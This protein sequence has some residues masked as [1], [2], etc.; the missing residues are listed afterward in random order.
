MVMLKALQDYTLKS[1]PA[2][3]SAYRS[4]ECLCELWCPSDWGFEPTIDRPKIFRPPFAR[5]LTWKPRESYTVGNEFYIN[6]PLFDFSPVVTMFGVIVTASFTEEQILENVFT[7]TAQGFADKNFRQTNKEIGLFQGR[8]S[9]YLQFFYTKENIR[10]EGFLLYQVSG[11]KLW[12][13]DATGG[14]DDMAQHRD[15]LKKVIA[16]LRTFDNQSEFHVMH[17]TISI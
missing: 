14:A 10:W 15:L 17:S 4:N 13:A 9:L 7:N 12:Y 8:Q 3:W 16:S 2:N 1:L 5:Y 11:E 6:S